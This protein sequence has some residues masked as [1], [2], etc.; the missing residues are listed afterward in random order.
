MKQ[1]KTKRI[2]C[3]VLSFLIPCGLMLVMLA[4]WGVMP[5]GSNTVLVG[6]AGGQYY[7]FAMLLR[8]LLRSG[9]SLLYSWRVGFGSSLIPEFAYYCANLYDLAACL[10]PEQMVAPFLCISV[11]TRL[12]TAG[13][14]FNCF[15]ISL[16]KKPSFAEPVFASL[17][18]LCG[19]AMADCFQ[20]IWLDCFAMVPLVLAS[21]VL[22]VRDRDIRLYPLVLGACLFCNCYFSFSIC[23]MAV[24]FWIGLLIVLRIPRGELLKAAGR[25]IGCSLLAAGLAAV[26]LIPTG[27]A[28]RNHLRRAWNIGAGQRSAS[29]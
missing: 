18:A 28:L 1:D 5:F 11:C 12:G 29:L 22:L 21:L 10:L 8:R 19:W 2:F 4:V 6:D 26:L 23:C 13:L 27:A 3:C 15:L 14:F 17:Y 9:E 24:L 7:P 16:R 25:F 20:L